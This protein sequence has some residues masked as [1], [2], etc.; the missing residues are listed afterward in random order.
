MTKRI[1][2]C[3]C[4]PFILPGLFP[5][6]AMP[7]LVGEL[8]QNE[9]GVKMFYPSL[10]FFVENQLHTQE[11]VL[12]AIE[13]IPLQFAEFL[14]SDWRRQDVLSYVL[15]TSGLEKIEDA[16]AFLR[17]LA[18]SAEMVQNR[19]A[20]QIVSLHPQILCHSLTFGDFNFAFSLFR[21][22]KKRLPQ[23]QILVGGS[24][25][26]PVFSKE[27]LRTSEDIDYVICDES[28]DTTVAL[29]KHILRGEP[30][31]NGLEEHIS[32][33]GKIAASTRI[34]RDMDRMG[35]PDFSDFLNTVNSLGLPKRQLVLPYEISR[36][37]WWGEKKPCTMCGYFGNQ[38]CFQIKS[39]DKVIRELR[40]LSEEF[41]VSYYRMTDLVEPKREYLM[42][43]QQLGMEK[44]GLHIIWEL[45]PNLSEKDIRILRKLGLFY[46]QIGF[47]SLSTGELQNMN[48]G[49][50]GVNNIYIL[51]LLFSYK[52]N[53]VWNYLYGFPEDERS[54]YEEAIRIIPSLY[55]LQP[56]DPREVWINKYS[57]MYEK[58]DPKELSPIGDNL[59]YNSSATTYNVFYKTEK[60]EALLP[61]YSE[62]VNAIRDW[63]IAFSKGYSLYVESL[64]E[65]SLVI[66]KDYDEERRYRLTGV[67]MILYLYCFQPRAMDDIMNETRLPLET[68]QGQLQSFVEEG[69]MVYLDKKYLSLAT[70]ST[71]Y[72]WE[73]FQV[74]P[75]E[76][77]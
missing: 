43:L 27:L 57:A 48:K 46:A 17:S 37:C 30:I 69:L 26:V 2:V 29:I 67:G 41:H 68:I 20:D 22:I 6:L 23:I 28:F 77:E 21:K 44:L 25:C 70:R 13:N 59:F 51:I 58:V 50:T 60:K 35:C 54:W 55:H 4:E 5:T 42:Q 15:K 24:N 7:T 32:R 33:K 75:P 63:R 52:I 31:E 73:R 65:E 12:K 18:E 36:G 61:I 47:E 56:P 66:V 34:M 8:V 14:F 62:L 64:T 38:T 3:V 49:T 71:E 40:R 74:L 53:C 45:R 16:E 1:D 76:M 11:T 9:I 19:I 39:P 72:R 10:T